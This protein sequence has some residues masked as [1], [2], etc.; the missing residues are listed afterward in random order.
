M[1]DSR[2]TY[3]LVT[4]ARNERDLIE[5]TIRSMAEATAM[6]DYRVLRA[7]DQTLDQTGAR[8]GLAAIQKVPLDELLKLVPEHVNLES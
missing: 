5:G 1:A 3:V 7:L 6:H 2:L 8:E 4:P